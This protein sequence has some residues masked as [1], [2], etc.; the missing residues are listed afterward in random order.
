[1]LSRS[2]RRLKFGAV[3]RHVIVEHSRAIIG[4]DGRK[5]CFEVIDKHSPATEFAD[6]E[7][8]AGFHHGIGD[9]FSEFN[10]PLQLEG[11]LA[12]HTLPQRQHFN[13]GDPYLSG[14]HKFHLAQA[15]GGSFFK[16]VDRIRPG[17]LKVEQVVRL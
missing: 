3:F 12:C 4:D 7:F 6:A 13:A 5:T 14:M 1:M 16:E 17:D 9:L 10:R 8:L 2:H 11:D 15:L